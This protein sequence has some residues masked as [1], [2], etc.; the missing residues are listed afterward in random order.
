[1]MFDTLVLVAIEKKKIL[2]YFFSESYKWKYIRPIG[3]LVDARRNH[4]ATVVG[5]FMIINGGISPK[6]QYLNDFWSF[7][8]SNKKLIC[9]NNIHYILYVFL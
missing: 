2:L 4:V 5:R 1:M 9:F 3:D 6:D 8:F 7:D